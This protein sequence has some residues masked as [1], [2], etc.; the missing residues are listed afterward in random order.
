MCERFFSC[1]CLLTNLVRSVKCVFNSQETIIYSGPIN[2]GPLRENE[3]LIRT[4]AVLKSHEQTIQ[5][6]Q[7][8]RAQPTTATR[9]PPARR[10]GARVHRKQ[11]HNSNDLRQKSNMVRLNAHCCLWQFLN[12]LGDVKYRTEKTLEKSQVMVRN[13]YRHANGVKQAS[14]T[15]SNRCG[16]VSLLIEN[17]ALSRMQSCFILHR[18]QQ[19]D[20]PRPSSGSVFFL[21]LPIDQDG[22]VSKMSNSRTT[23]YNDTGPFLTGA[24]PIAQV[25]R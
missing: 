3:I 9:H 22:P 12:Q 23:I 17:I 14:L 8:H 6:N 18:H 4:I 25:R 5:T 10:P 21:R 7:R 13:L 16:H 19:Q 15:A 2:W 24:K 20:L 11:Y 1:D